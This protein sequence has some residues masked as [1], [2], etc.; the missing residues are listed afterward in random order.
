[1][2]D[3]TIGDYL[4]ASPYP[5]IDPFSYAD[6]NV[7]FA[8]ESETRTLIRL[9]VIYRGILLYSD[10]GTGK[11][12]LVNAGLIPR[13]VDEGFRPERIR[14]QPTED[15]EIIVERLS[16]YATGEKRLLPSIFTADDDHA[17]VVLSVK[18]FL[19]TVRQ[20]ADDVHPLL[21]FDQFEEWITLFEGSSARQSVD[22]VAAS[23][24]KIRNAIVSLVNDR[25]VPVKVLIVLREDYLA[26]LEPLFE[27]CPRL[28]DHYLR[29]TPLNGDQVYRAIRGPFEEYS[30][31]YQPELSIPLAEK[32]QQQFEARS[33]G[34]DIRLTEVQIVCRSLFEAGVQGQELEAYFIGNGVQGI[35][36]EYLEH[37]LESLAPYQ[38]YAAIALLARMV[39]SAGT[40]NVISED[41]LLGRVEVE[42]RIPRELLIQTLNGLESET[43]LVRRERRREV[44][45]YEITSEFL[46]EWIQ[47]N[48]R[49]RRE[50]KAAEEATERERK[51]AEEA[52]KR[53]RQAA[54]QRWNRLLRLAT[55]TGVIL[56][57]LASTFA[58]IANSNR[59]TAAANAEGEATAK[60]VAM[61]NAAQAKKNEDEAATAKAEAEQ[62][63]ARAATG[64]AQAIQQKDIAE[65]YAANLVAVLTA[66]APQTENAT[67]PPTD[68]PIPTSDGPVSPTPRIAT[69]TPTPSSTPTPNVDATATIVA[70]QEQLSNLQATQTAI[71]PAPTPAPTTSLVV[72]AKSG[73]QTHRTHRLGTVRPSGAIVRNDI[74]LNHAAAP[75]WSPDGRLAFF[76]EPGTGSVNRDIDREGIWTIGYPPDI[77]KLLYPT[78][79]V[80][81]LT[82]SPK[83]TYLAF[84][85]DRP[86]QPA[87]V[88]IID[89]TAGREIGKPF[90]GQQP[91][92]YPDENKLII[93]AEPS[94]GGCGLRQVALNGHLEMQIPTDCT[95]S[96]P[97]ISPDGQYLAF[98]SRQAGNW[99]IYLM[100]LPN[101]EPQRV[102]KERGTDTTPVFSQDGQE[103]FY[104]SDS[105]NPNWQVIVM[106][107]DGSNKVAV[108]NDV[109]ASNDD[110]LAR[111]AV[112]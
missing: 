77:P 79:H 57:I 15:Q 102:T 105:I 62:N 70:V 65:A 75:A 63:A 7:F 20:Q 101:G 95:A 12:S 100:E 110:G 18:D 37:A 42:E 49:E 1:M 21:I 103:L 50:R 96:Y 25:E 39:T 84:E 43:K 58:V 44:N 51:A 30:G 76:A 68:T 99:D 86:N 88:V 59:Q 107:L 9:I 106:D 72:Y 104:R 33:E 90:L 66:E 5:G 17:Q 53:E 61:H 29:L 74:S 36:E 2:S 11:S 48:G 60:A 3:N 35:L 54:L 31:K 19:E 22:E 16:E 23:Q 10:S 32:I 108:R 6:R 38:Q 47:E 13:A 4:P 45:F 34:T 14:I 91:A 80:K 81:N 64:E 82:W 71:A 78:D 73:G 40:R 56:A 41:D 83:G 112:Y 67:R 98:S 109:G 111:P 28:P 93:K 94:G 85:I 55:L 87:E 92:W 52:A 26:K 97:V 24:D 27:R 46:I 89:A 8:R 69:A